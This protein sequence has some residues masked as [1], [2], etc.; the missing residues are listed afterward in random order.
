MMVLIIKA[1]EFDFW[2]VLCG[3][4]D[5]TYVTLRR[6]DLKTAAELSAVWGENPKSGH[7]F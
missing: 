6:S 1:G 3:F 2:E 7:V 4:M 5:T